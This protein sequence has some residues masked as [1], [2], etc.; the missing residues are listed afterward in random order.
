M[1]PLLELREELKE[2]QDPAKR[3]D[4]RDLKR[5]IGQ[6]KLVSDDRKAGF[7]KKILKS[8]MQLQDNKDEKP[9][10][11]SVLVP[12]PY[13]LEFCIEFLEKLLLAQ[14]KV[15]QNGPDPHMDLISEAELREIQRIWRMERGDWKNT[16]YQIFEKVTGQKLELPKEDLT[17]FGQIEQDTLEE[18][19]A[20]NNVPHLL[21]SKLLN[22]EYESQGM[23]RH[24]KIYPKI[25]G[26]LSEE[27]RDDLDAIVEDLQHQKNMA[28]EYG[29]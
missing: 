1:E 14:K 27:W 29:K 10:P 12:G 23:T 25:N 21:V 20:Q 18:V 16:A 28:K 24:S 4:V 17:G 3:R 7:D 19:C 15:R 9:D 11:Y 13:T 5:R 8:K 2:T 22:A 6:M 26:I